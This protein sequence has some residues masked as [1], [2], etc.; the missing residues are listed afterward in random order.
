MRLSCNLITADGTFY[1]LGEPVPD[2]EVPRHA[3]AYRISEREGRQLAREMR[4][5]REMVA[6]WREKKKKREAIA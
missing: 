1:S 4:E 2:A 3:L 6:A 5:W